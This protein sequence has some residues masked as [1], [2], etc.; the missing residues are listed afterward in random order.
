MFKEI[1]WL[2]NK[3]VNFKTDEIESVLLFAFFW[4]LF[5]RKIAECKAEISKSRDYTSQL[6]FDSRYDE[7]LEEIWEYLKN[8]Y[9]AIGVVT[10]KF[11]D[12]EF[13][14]NDKKEFVQATLLA[15]DSSKADKYESILRI[16]FR[17]RN[18]LLHGVKDIIQIN[19]QN[20]LFRNANH[21]LSILLDI[22]KNN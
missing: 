20:G 1:D 8:R 12:F 21:F 16:I 3:I 11:K 15:Y 6:D 22:K 10:D 7:D 9:V 18:N 4:N 13:K 17:L 14:P 5:E 19:E 2:K